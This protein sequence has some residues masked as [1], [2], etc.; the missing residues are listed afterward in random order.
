VFRAAS[1]AAA[2]AIAQSD[3]FHIHGCRHNAVHSWSIRF[4]QQQIA[5]ALAAAFA[6]PEAS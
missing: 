3:P 6:D 4:A 1:K 2:E 5:N